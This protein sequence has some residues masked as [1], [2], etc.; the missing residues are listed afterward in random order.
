MRSILALLVVALF[1]LVLVQSALADDAAAASPAGLSAA[2][3]DA[4]PVLV[5]QS[6]NNSS[7][8]GSTRIPRGLIR[9]AIFGVI[10]LFGA[11]AWVVRQVTG[12][13]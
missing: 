4:L 6:S 8:S 11:G 2:G 10:A 3:A 7:S 9:L 1:A 5:A 12:S 13:S